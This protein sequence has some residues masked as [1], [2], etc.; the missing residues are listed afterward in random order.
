[1][2]GGIT[3][4]TIELTTA[5]F[6]QS[7]IFL[8]IYFIKLAMA[9]KNN[10]RVVYLCFVWIVVSTVL[11]QTSDGHHCANYPLRKPARNLVLYFHNVIY[12]STNAMVNYHTL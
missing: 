1:M 5:L 2:G 3:T 11:L 9:I 8:Y 6:P 7:H 4:A 12:D 10:N